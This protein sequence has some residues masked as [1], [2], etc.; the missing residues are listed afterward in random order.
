MRREFTKKQLAEAFDYALGLGYQM[1]FTHASQEEPV[2]NNPENKA[3][4]KALFEEY[5]TENLKPPYVPNMKVFATFTGEDGSMGFVKG[6]EYVLELHDTEHG[7]V[8]VTTSTGLN[9]DYGSTTAFL[10][11]WNNVRP[12]N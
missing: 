7:I 9:C 4:G 1:G 5:Y 8:T 10:R 2:M 11:N 3:E 12:R 6:V